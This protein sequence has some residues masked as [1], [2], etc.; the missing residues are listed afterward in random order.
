MS[1]PIDLIHFSIFA[2]ISFTGIKPSS[3]QETA[4]R[5]LVAQGSNVCVSTPPQ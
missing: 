2:V 3:V 1:V 5:S 4:F